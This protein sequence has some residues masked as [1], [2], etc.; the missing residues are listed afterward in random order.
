MNKE[1]CSLE[2]RDVSFR[3]PGK[4]DPALTSTD[5]KVGDHELCALLGPNGSGKSTLLKVAS[6]I[7]SQTSGTVLLW[8]KDIR[9]Y[10]GADRAKL[11]SYMPQFISSSVPFTVTELAAMGR[12]PYGTVDESRITSA[13]EEVG[14]TDKANSYIGALSGGEVRRAYLAMMLVQGAGTLLLDEPLANLDIR[15]Q[16]ELIETLTNIVKAGDISV[17]M[18]IHDIPASLRFERA[19]IL[20]EGR[21]HAD[22]PP[23][24][25]I[26]EELLSEVFKV[27][28]DDLSL[29]R[30]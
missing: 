16:I 24:E 13:I 4:K 29:L 18:A 21:L 30:L 7:L 17:L 14:L 10:A 23:R 22:G 9:T 19:L 5:L 15:Y 8:G 12:Y 3:Y 6:G 1:G 26:T 25:I 27:K 11:V 2:L 28:R 20:K